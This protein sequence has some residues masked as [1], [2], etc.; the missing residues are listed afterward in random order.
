MLS[1]LGAYRD[2]AAADDV[3]ARPCHVPRGSRRLADHCARRHQRDIP[4]TFPS[5]KKHL[6]AHPPPTLRSANSPADVSAAAIDTPSG[7]SISRPSN[8]NRIVEVCSCVMLRLAGHFGR[9]PAGGRLQA[10]ARVQVNRKTAVTTVHFHAP[11]GNAPAVAVAYETVPGTVRTRSPSSRRHVRAMP[12]RNSS[13]V[14]RRPSQIQCECSTGGVMF[15]ASATSAART[16]RDRPNPGSAA[17]GPDRI[18]Q[19]NPR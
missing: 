10:L 6:D 13:P 15:D 14:R 7:Q 9:H 2:P 1:V 16:P 17:T 5:R 8:V 4:G 12:S 19:C 3:V 18:R 11:F